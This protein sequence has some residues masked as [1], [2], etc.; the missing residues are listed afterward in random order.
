MCVFVCWPVFV[1]SLRC[2]PVAFLVRLLIRLVGSFFSCVFWT[3]WLLGWFAIC[4]CSHALEPHIARFSDATHACRCHEASRRPNERI[5]LRLG[6]SLKFCIAT[7]L[8][9]V[10][11]FYSCDTGPFPNCHMKGIS[12]GRLSS[13]YMGLLDMPHSWT[14]ATVPLRLH[15]EPPQC[16]CFCLALHTP[17]ILL[18]KISPMIPV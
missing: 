11:W 16:S 9:P 2:L 12:R 5:G 7:L 18:G 6:W 15:L 10:F 3:D 13:T 1:C 14:P 8:V 17:V 4:L